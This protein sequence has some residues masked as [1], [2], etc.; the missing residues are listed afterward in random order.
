MNKQM[1]IPNRETTK[2]KRNNE[3]EEKKR[4]RKREKEKSTRQNISKQN[5]NYPDSILIHSLSTH[6]FAAIIGC[7]IGTNSNKKKSKEKKR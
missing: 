5:T 3:E 7:H 2:R 4:K 1:K 6:H